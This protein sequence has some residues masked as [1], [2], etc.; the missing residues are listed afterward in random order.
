MP[1]NEERADHG[2]AAIEA[3]GTELDSYD[4][5][6]NLTDTLTNLMHWA[7]SFSIKPLDFDKALRLAVV[8]FNAEVEPD[9]IEQAAQASR[10]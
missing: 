9:D 8:H 1:T 6:A 2:E 10:R 4:N 3:L 7:A 5:E